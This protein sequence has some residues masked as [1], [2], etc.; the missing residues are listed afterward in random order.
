MAHSGHEMTASAREL[1]RRPWAR[2]ALPLLCIAVLLSTDLLAGPA[3]RI[4]GLMVA[5]PALAAGFLGPGEVLVVVAFTLPSVVWTSAA[6]HT[7]DIANFPVSFGTVVLIGAA[8]VATAAARRRRERELAQARWVASVTQRVLLHPLPARLGA[9]TLSSL[10]I[11]ADEEA[12]I[13]GD[14]YAAAMVEQRTRVMVGDVQGK[15]LAAVETAGHLLRAFH[16]AARRGVAL[17]GLPDYLDRSLRDEMAGSAESE[18]GD[19]A[20]SAAARRRLLEGFVTAVVVDVGADGLVRVANRGH[21]P[22]LLIHGDAV[23]V[24]EPSVAAVPL[25]LGD[26]ASGAEHLDC[27]E[28]AGGD[29]LL[30]YTDGVIEARDAAGTFYP[31]ADRL[32]GLTAHGPEAL[33]EALR[34]QL[35]THAG[36]MLG[37]DVA[38][39]ALHRT[40]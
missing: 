17:A 4:G 35:L 16:R 13:G 21:P 34:A 19:A 3:I 5:V 40:A 18:A 29:T 30:L 10:Y 14:L 15:G 9:L 37:D 23:R 12:S 31:L 36:G 39:V 8:S 2:V 33:L 38:M 6:N 7:L 24:L 32:A 22:P 27:F 20:E 1:L 26:L 25:G 11:A 28:M